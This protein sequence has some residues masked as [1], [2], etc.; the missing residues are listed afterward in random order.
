MRKKNSNQLISITRKFS[1]SINEL[2]FSSPVTL[3]YNPLEYASKVFD[4]YLS[5]YSS[6]KK[7]AIFLGM[8]PGPWGMA[9]TGIPFGEVRMVRDWLG[10]KQKV[11]KPKNENP[12]RPIL[13]FDCNRSEVSGAR[14]WGFFKNHFEQAEDFFENFFVLNYCPLLFFD[15]DLKNLTPDKL[16]KS[17]TQILFQLCDGYLRQVQLA[18]NADCWIGVG[19]FAAQR[20]KRAFADSQNIEVFSI[21][22]PSPANPQANR[23]WASVATRQLAEH[24]INLC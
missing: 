16:K 2:S 18:L 6:G 14:L 8:N 4:S 24:G 1:E 5:K 22:H 10:I 15:K 9:Q 21:L 19:A 23:G 20:A 17:D 11:L 3:V 12:K 13:G 7:K